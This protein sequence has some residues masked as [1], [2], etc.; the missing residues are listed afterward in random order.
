MRALADILMFAAAALV[1]VGAGFIYP[2]AG[3][4]V[5]GVALGAIAFRIGQTR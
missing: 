3:L 1:S 4:I 2:P 5:A